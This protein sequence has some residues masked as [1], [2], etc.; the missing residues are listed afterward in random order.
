MTV[1]RGDVSPFMGE[2][3]MNIKNGEIIQYTYHGKA[4]Y[5]K[6]NS[7]IDANRAFSEITLDYIF[8]LAKTCSINFPLFSCKYQYD[9]TYG[10][11]TNVTMKASLQAYYKQHENAL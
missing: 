5:E 11:P 3:V 7:T 10:Y 8:D 2:I 4:I 6:G 1:N 9:P